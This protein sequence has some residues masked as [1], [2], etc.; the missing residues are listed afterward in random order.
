MSDFP[1]GWNSVTLGA[2]QDRGH[3]LVRNGFS[4]GEHTLNSGG[5][6]HMRPFNVTEDC[7]LSFDQVK[8]ISPKEGFDQFALTAGDV[9]F[10][11]TNSEELVGKC[12]HWSGRDGLHVLSNHM[13]IFRL[14]PHADLDS[15][16]LN[17]YLFWLWQSGASRML[18]RR[19]VNQASIGLERLRQIELPLPSSD[20]QLQ[21]ADTLYSI[22]RSI[23]VQ[24]ELMKLLRNAKAAIMETVL[25]DGTRGE[26]LK[27]TE[28]GQ[29]PE[30]WSV[31]RIGDVAKISTGTTPATDQAKYYGGTIPFAKTAEID[32]NILV[33]TQQSVTQ[34]AVERYNLKLYPP[35]TVFLAMYGQGKTRGRVALLGITATTTQNTAAIEPLPGL[36]S[37]YLWHYLLSKYLALRNVGNLGHLSHLNLGYV[38]DIVIPVPLEDEQQSIVASLDLIEGRLANASATRDTL[39]KLFA[40]TLHQLMTGVLRMSTEENEVA[41]A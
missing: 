20:E 8:Y 12:A 17:F 10:N 28:I 2:L 5:V 13:T 23:E 26:P 39:R 24:E 33:A 22:Q 18:C 40:T 9:L 19:H 11:N 31:R 27:D 4:C 14:L 21:I 1:E 37:R 3:L 15:R 7:R 29:V 16:F 25:R 32:N 41:N 36:N 30:S 6:P 34:E 35:G 38:K